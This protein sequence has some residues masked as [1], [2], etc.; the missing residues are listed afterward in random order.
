[1]GD[2]KLLE[3]VI[4]RNCQFLQV[5]HTA[6]FSASVRTVTREKFPGK[7]KQLGSGILPGVGVPLATQ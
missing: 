1:M 2:R 5:G 7:E 6:M 3:D 4:F